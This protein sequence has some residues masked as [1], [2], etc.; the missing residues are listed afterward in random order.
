MELFS[1]VASIINRN[2]EQTREIKPQDRLREDLFIDSFD[3]MMIGCEIEDH[4]HV[5]IDPDELK[6]LTVVQDIV[7]KLKLKITDYQ[8]INA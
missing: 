4:F 7:D 1:E 3:T 8:M 5:D 6:C 2:K